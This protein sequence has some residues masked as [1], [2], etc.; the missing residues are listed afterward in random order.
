MNT[1]DL[2][3]QM[4][5]LAG[6]I[7]QSTLPDIGVSA[8]RPEQKMDFQALLNEKRTQADRER[9]EQEPQKT[10]PS[11]DTEAGKTE[12]KD[13]DVAAQAAGQGV[14]LMLDL[15]SVL[16][17]GGIVPFVGC[18]VMLLWRERR[19]R[20]QHSRRI[21]SVLVKRLCRKKRNRRLHLGP[22]SLLLDRRRVKDKERSSRSR[23][24]ASTW[25]SLRGS[26]SRVESSRAQTRR[27][28]WRSHSSRPEAIRSCS[29]GRR[30]LP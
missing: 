4:A 5:Y 16:A 25:S 24:K 10:D 21:L 22:L 7:A 9:T 20:S 2:T 15:S 14:P 13:E 30:P 26:R 1:S 11:Q 17:G 3:L 12:Q 6:Q 19:L 18:A 23:R 29:R 8:G 27:W 28:M